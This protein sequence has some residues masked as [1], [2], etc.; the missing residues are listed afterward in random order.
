MIKHCYC[1]VQNLVVVTVRAND[2]VFYSRLSIVSGRLGPNL[3]LRVFQGLNLMVLIF[4]PY[5]QFE[6]TSVFFP[7]G[8]NHSASWK[9]FLFV[10]RNYSIVVSSNIASLCI[11]VLWVQ[12]ILCC[13]YAEHDLVAFTLH[14]FLY[15][16]HVHRSG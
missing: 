4:F 9:I 3:T 15:Q 10:R 5:Y 11:V 7:C 6:L 16:T 1:V 8:L 13:A 12:Q 2:P 14:F